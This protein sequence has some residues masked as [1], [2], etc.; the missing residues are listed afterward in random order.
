LGA[1]L[2]RLLQGRLLQGRL[3]QG[4]LWWRHRP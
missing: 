2:R 3:L 1:G 4:R